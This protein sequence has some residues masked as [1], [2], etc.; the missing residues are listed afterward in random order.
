MIVI[1]RLVELII[2]DWSRRQNIRPSDLTEDEKLKIIWGEKMTTPETA[3]EE[4]DEL[5]QR[6][7][8]ER[9]R[10]EVA[11]SAEET[12]GAEAPR[13]KFVRKEQTLGDWRER[14]LIVATLYKRASQMDIVAPTAMHLHASH[15]IFPKEILLRFVQVVDMH[16]QTVGLLF[17]QDNP[18]MPQ[19][20]EVIAILIPPQKGALYHTET[21]I[22]V[23]MEHSAIVANNLQFMGILRAGG[24]CD[25][26]HTGDLGLLGRTLVEN[27]VVDTRDIVATTLTLRDGT[28]TLE[29]AV[30]TTEGLRWAREN[31]RS[32][33]SRDPEELPGGLLTTCRGSWSNELQG[34]FIVPEGIWNYEFRALW[35]D[36]KMFRYQCTVG[37]PLEYFAVEHRPHHFSSFQRKNEPDV[38]VMD[39]NE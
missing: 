26:F 39:L 29:C 17:G 8:A 6:I 13:R 16:V 27:S 15:L 35:Q 9:G 38:D 36:G 31:Y 10:Q 12:P 19:L 20:K 11:K 37:N 4:A 30:L 22:I 33:L 24:G 28:L 34:M 3:A 2:A 32:Q 1:G 21:P 25:T 23:P 5:E 18:K 7:Q 14:A